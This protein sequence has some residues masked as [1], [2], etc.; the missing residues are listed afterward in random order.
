VRISE[1]GEFGLI[2][3]ISRFL[4]SN[5]ADV[6]VGIG[7][8]VAVMRVSGPEYLVATCDIQVENVHFLRSS[9]SPY[10][11]GKKIVA[12]N[13]SDIAAVGGD[14]TWGLVSLALPSDIEVDFVDALYR[15][16]Q[17]QIQ[18][19]GACIVGGNMSQIRAE[20]VI[21]L[22][23]LGRVLPERMLLRSGAREGDAILVTGV[24]GDSRA[25]L[26]LVLNP[27][28]Q[29]SEKTRS[30][31]VQRHLTP[32][33]RLHEGQKLARTGK[34]T[35]MVDVSDGL[36]GDMG[37]ICR[38]SHVGAE[39]YAADLPVSSQ[40]RETAG[41]AGRDPYEWALFGGEDY[42]LL[43]TADPAFV[44]EIQNAVTG[45]TGTSIRVIGR[46]VGESQGIV[47]RLP[48][49]REMSHS[50]GSAAWDHFAGR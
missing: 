44:H 6:V 41:L 45:E 24:L 1:L 39:I 32:V 27:H 49:G 11:L 5:P 37:H 19:A 40:C 14:P 12:I 50:K 26:E 35:A 23:L 47:A 46:V 7:D 15:G 42:E 16:M 13:V 28:L 17:E 48:D 18:G 8:D 25:G 20:V 22:F 30:N 36:M 4:G 33:P 9:I 3:R 34:V 29:A 38:A 10:Q 2:G 31:L 21:D 43:F